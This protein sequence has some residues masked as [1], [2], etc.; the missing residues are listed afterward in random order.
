M[1]CNGAK[2][3]L[4]E[5]Y[6]NM[7]YRIDTFMRVSVAMQEQN[8]TTFLLDDSSQIFRLTVNYGSCRT[9]FHEL[10]KHGEYNLF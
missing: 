2:S 5:G 1:K 6:L 3:G 9:T 10:T 8:A 4:Y 7:S